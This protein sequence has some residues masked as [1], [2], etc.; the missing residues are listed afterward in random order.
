MEEV[1][2]SSFSIKTK[3]LN[4]NL[5][6]TALMIILPRKLSFGKIVILFI[7]KSCFLFT[8]NK[9]I[10][11]LAWLSTKV[12]TFLNKDASATHQFISCFRATYLSTSFPAMP[13]LGKKTIG[14]CIFRLI[15]KAERLFGLIRTI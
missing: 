4:A 2:R 6:R 12:K 14:L 1:S 11:Q 8:L 9:R 5:A 13:R 15:S 7:T 10:K 3:L